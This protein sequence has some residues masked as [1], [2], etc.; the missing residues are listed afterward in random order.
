VKPH[1][2][3]C[4]DEFASYD[5]LAEHGYWHKRVNHAAGEHVGPTGGCTN[6][7]EEHAERAAPDAGYVA[8]RFHPL[9][10]C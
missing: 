2:T 1:G 4:T 5:D 8:L 6:N 7:V 10:F 9:N 3:V